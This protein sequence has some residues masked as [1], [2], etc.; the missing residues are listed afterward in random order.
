MLPSPA[1]GGESGIYLSEHPEHGDWRT[2][3]ALVPAATCLR[4]PGVR[5]LLRVHGEIDLNVVRNECVN[6]RGRSREGRRPVP[7]L[8]SIGRRRR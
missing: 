8:A 3:A 5:R 2:H 1:N 6:A 7:G 4:L